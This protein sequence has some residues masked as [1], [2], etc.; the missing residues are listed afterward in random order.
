MTK[1]FDAIVVGGGLSGAMAAMAMA[2]EGLSVLLAEKSGSL[3]G[4]ATVNYV[5]P[6]ME[7]RMT[8]NGRRIRLNR[9]LFSELL[10]RLNAYHALDAREVIYN[11][12]YLKLALD[13]MA[14]KYGVTVLFHAT[15]FDAEAKNKRVKTLSFITAAG[16]LEFSCDSAIDATGDALLSHLVGCPYR[17]GRAEDE[18]CQP[19]TLCFRLSGVDCDAF[20]SDLSRL[21]TI[22]AEERAKGI[23]KNPRE[24]LLVFRHASEGV[25]HFNATRVLSSPL[26]PFEKSEAEKI[27]RRQML[28]ILDFLKRH[29]PSCQNATLLSSASEIGVRESRMIEGL[30][31]ITEDDILN[32][33]KFPDAIAAGN[34]GVDIHSPDGSGTRRVKMRDGTF[35]TIPYRATIP[36]GCDNLLV[37]GRALSSTHEAQS[38][39]RILPNVA[40]I[41]EGAGI[42]LSL[43]HKLKCP[44]YALDH[45]TLAKAIDAYD[46]VEREEETE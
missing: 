41:G 34:Y 18:K 8:K 42:A 17:V 10:D 32:R 43:C 23:I 24:N 5:L 39:Y 31:T 20:F 27:A 37:V 4:A 26:D 35:Y 46:L 38:S 45:P 22:W 2:R 15:L 9:G 14:E 6:F 44:T 30:Y 3:G 36:L 13:E 33:R 16:K 29:A 25:L 1:H 21:N 28:E 11:E 40:S 19:M 7:Y 12:E